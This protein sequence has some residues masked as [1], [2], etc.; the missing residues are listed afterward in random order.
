VK[1]VLRLKSDRVAH[2][3]LALAD[4]AACDGHSLLHWVVRD[5]ELAFGRVTSAIE[6]TVAVG[7][8]VAL[9]AEV[10]VRPAPE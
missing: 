2:L 4:D 8:I 7:V 9:L 5:T 1:L 3:N 6:L 10:S